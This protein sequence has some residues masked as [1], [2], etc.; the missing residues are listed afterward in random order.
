MYKFLVLEILEARSLRLC[1]CNWKL[2]HH[3]ILPAEK[4]WEDALN[5]K[6]AG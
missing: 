1:A 5:E 3:I 4:I 2:A 6:Q